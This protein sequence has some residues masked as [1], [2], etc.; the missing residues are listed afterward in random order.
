MLPG[1]EEFTADLKE[2]DVPTAELIAEGLN[3]IIG[4]ENALS[5]VKIRKFIRAKYN[6]VVGD[7]KFRKIIQYIRVNNMVPCLCACGNGYYKAANEQE[8][9]EWKESMRKRIR[10]QEF[11]LACAEYFNDGKETL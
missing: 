11:T 6:L 10:Q 7:P 4:K 1:F 2:E 5:N 9:E 3:K 8:W